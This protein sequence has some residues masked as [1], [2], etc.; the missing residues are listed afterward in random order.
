M[1]IIPMSL[2]G[3]EE[4]MR[5]LVRLNTDSH[6]SR[7]AYNY[8]LVLPVVDASVIQQVQPHATWPGPRRTPAP[9]PPPPPPTPRPRPTGAPPPGRAA[10]GDSTS[11]TT[12]AAMAADDA[13]SVSGPG[14]AAKPFLD[15]S[16]ERLYQSYSVKQKRAGVQC[17]LAAAVLYDVFMLVLPGP[18]PVQDSLTIGL[19][20][21]FLGLNLA[22]LA[23]TLRPYRLDALWAAVPYV[24]WF[25][26]ITQL[27]AHFFLRNYNGTG[28]DALGWA[29]LLDYLLYVTLPLRLR[30]CVLLSIATCGLYGVTL[31]G[32]A[33]KGDATLPA[34]SISLYVYLEIHRV[35]RGLRLGEVKRRERQAH[36]EEFPMSVLRR[37]VTKK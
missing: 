16:L 9:S 27:L 32:L 24:A 30:Y 28:R 17:F 4:R 15:P 14:E 19:M 12:A 5:A 11:P 21:A 36:G 7:K 18:G 31:Y 6:A 22:L 3:E 29:L 23:W 35:A 26:A 25:L 20:A 1:T 2:R 10:D 34:Q 37:V 13:A 8:A 33:Y